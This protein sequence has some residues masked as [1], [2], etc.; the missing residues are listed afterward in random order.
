MQE[1]RKAILS[2]TAEK[3][4]GATIDPLGA[5]ERD[6]LKCMALCVDLDDQA[7]SA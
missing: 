7:G 3:Y 4:A 2:Q 1:V 5:W 6:T